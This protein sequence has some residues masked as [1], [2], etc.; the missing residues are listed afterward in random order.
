MKILTLILALLTIVSCGKSPQKIS[1]SIKEDF[2]IKEKGKNCQSLNLYS[3][4]ADK[5]NIQSLFECLK[6]DKSYPELYKKIKSVEESEFNIFNDIFNR[7]YFKNTKT[8]NKLLESLI[9][10]TSKSSSRSLSHLIKSFLAKKENLSSLVNITESLKAEKVDVSA[11]FL[12][13]YLKFMSSLKSEVE[14]GRKVFAKD[15][16]QNDVKGKFSQFLKSFLEDILL[17]DTEKKAFI[18]FLNDKDWISDF[19]KNISKDAFQNIAFFLVENPDFLKGVKTYQRGINE[20]RFNC[21]EQSQSYIVDHRVELNWQLE[22]L[23]YLNLKNFNVEMRDLVTRFRLYSEICF[24]DDFNPIISKLLK[25]FNQFINIDGGFNLLKKFAQL[26]LDKDIDDELII[27]FFMSK[28]FTELNE[29]LKML[30]GKENFL[31][32]I[33]ILLKS[34][35]ESDYENIKNILNT[36]ETD[37][38]FVR[39]L[40]RV[41][42]ESLSQSDHD[43]LIGYVVDMFITSK[44]IYPAFKLMNSVVESLPNESK[45]FLELVL[46]SDIKLREVSEYLLNDENAFEELLQFFEEDALFSIISL[47]QKND[48]KLIFSIDDQV[49]E[50][51]L[52]RSQVKKSDKCLG[53]LIALSSELSL[54]KYISLYPLECIAKEDKKENFA[55]KIVRWAKIMNSQFSKLYDLNIVSEYGILNTRFMHFLHQMVHVTTKYVSSAGDFSKETVNTVK[56]F[57]FKRKYINSIESALDWVLKIDQEKGLISPVL[58]VTKDLNSND[59]DRTLKY[60]FDLLAELSFEDF[61]YKCRYLKDCAISISSIEEELRKN[62]LLLSKKV[63]TKVLLELKES[64]FLV[65]DY[66]ELIRFLGSES[67]RFGLRAKSIE[68]IL[69]SVDFENSYYAIFFINK[70]AEAKNYRSTVT[71]LKKN[72]KLATKLSSTFKMMRIFPRDIKTRFKSVNSNLD[73]L[74]EFN[75]DIPGKDYSYGDVLIGLM[76]SIQKLSPARSRSIRKVSLPRSKKVFGHYG[77]YLTA[78]S[79]KGYLSELS[80]LLKIN[81]ANSAQT[82][83]SFSDIEIL[84]EKINLD[85]LGEK[86][87]L[88]ELPINEKILEKILNISPESLEILVSYLKVLPTVNITFSASEINLKSYNTLFKILSDEDVDYVSLKETLSNINDVDPAYL[89]K[90][91]QYSLIKES[92]K[93]KLEYGLRDMFIES[94]DSLIN[95]FKDILAHFKIN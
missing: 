43:N 53:R 60:G 46:Q 91:I 25:T 18:N 73:I 62:N 90:L 31:D 81:I 19:F 79:S 51:P 72:F 5:K 85:F 50:E 55:I 36:L 12:F 56:N 57:L 63:I 33:Y 77:H 80:H 2:Y 41:W 93:T 20:S 4:I 37:P 38:S 11:D 49:K 66:I 35:D 21:S 47:I 84:L 68:R 17:G 70:L 3:N 22:N 92:G 26:S 86:I 39:S 82:N 8:R 40:R 83:I 13:A 1:K 74:D 10:K 95:F 75:R 23:F 64:D 32:G 89:S 34:L 28:S 44:D 15:F 76:R 59:F 14:Y 7:T 71:S 65:E 16:L 87:L 42:L 78:L 29:V 54:V 61:G 9:N 88:E 94:N 27:N 45:L 69:S 67:Q 24:Q 30:Y 58:D 6:F 52:F 48:E